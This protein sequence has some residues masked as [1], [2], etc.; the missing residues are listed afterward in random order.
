MPQIKQR[1]LNGNALNEDE[2]ETEYEVVKNADFA[3]GFSKES[4]EK[5]RADILPKLPLK[6][7]TSDGQ[8]IVVEF[9]SEPRKV[10]SNKLPRGEAWF[11][12]VRHGDGEYSMV[13]PD[14]LRFSLLALKKEYNWTQFTGQ[15]VSITA[16]EGTISTPRFKGKAK[17]YKAVVVK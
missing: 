13:I 15:R 4:L 9:I 11:I 16:Q 17:T 10:R 2:T 7:L 6:E 5:A 14:S 8:S 3:E 1:D 12:D